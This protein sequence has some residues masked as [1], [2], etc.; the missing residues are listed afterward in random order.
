MKKEDFEEMTGR[1]L[2]PGTT[3][4]DLD[5]QQAEPEPTFGGWTDSQIK[6]KPLDQIEA[7]IRSGELGLE[8]LRETIANEE[9]RIDDLRLIKQRKLQLGG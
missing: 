7:M 9:A 3:Y 5:E 8:K 6:N 2:A 1:K 4:I